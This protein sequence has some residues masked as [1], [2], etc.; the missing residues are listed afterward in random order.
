MVVVRQYST[1]RQQ[2]EER[3]KIAGSTI[4]NPLSLTF[5][6]SLNGSRLA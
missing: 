2:V 5:R 1:Q 6:R 3:K 4:F